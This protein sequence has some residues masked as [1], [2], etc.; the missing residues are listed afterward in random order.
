[1]SKYIKFLLQGVKY[2]LYL[3]GATAATSLAYLQYINYKIG[4]IEIDRDALIKFYGS[5]ES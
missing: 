4:S 2:S 3:G 1:M 5:K